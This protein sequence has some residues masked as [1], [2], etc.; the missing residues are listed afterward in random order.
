[1]VI[2]FSG[3]GNSKSIAVTLSKL[4]GT[5]LTPLEH[6]LITRP[7]SRQLRLSAPD[8]PVIWVFPVYSWGIP[9]VVVR[10]I[11]EC[12]IMDADKVGHH[13]VVSCGDDTGTIATQWRKLLR[14]RNWNPRSATSVIMPNTYVLMKGFDTDQP[15]LVKQK[16][17]NAQERILTACRRIRENRD[18]DLMETGR[19]AW[20]KSHLIYPWFIK[21][22]MSP[23]PFHSTDACTSCRLCAREC[24][25]DNITMNKENR[26]VW[27]DNCALCLRCYH[28]CPAHAI[29]YGN[30]TKNK[31]QY[32][33]P[34]RQ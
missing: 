24:P 16:L 3:N 32:P 26:P 20:I 30:K 12:D 5:S 31:H 7:H 27:H 2:Y 14:H 21:N 8:E 25:M 23:R 17:D 22:A 28:R 34:D 15:S 29:A 19:F 9:P 1:M 4:L 18:D 10:F 6:E 33:G 13:L 11:K